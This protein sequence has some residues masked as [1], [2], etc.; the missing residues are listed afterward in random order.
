MQQVGGDVAR[1]TP[2]PACL[3]GAAQP[4]WSAAE[5]NKLGYD[6][7]EC[8]CRQSQE[9]VEGVGVEVHSDVSVR[10]YSERDDADEITDIVESELHLHLSVLEAT[11][12]YTGMLRRAM[13]A[14]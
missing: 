9:L 4:L 7:K 8:R 5:P 12:P 14:V 2:P 13:C 11:K 3:C 6:F 10:R 1:E